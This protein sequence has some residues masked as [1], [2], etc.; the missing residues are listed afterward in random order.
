MAEVITDLMAGT[1]SDEDRE[2]FLRSVGLYESLSPLEA[3]AIR[4]EWP[5]RKIL[6]VIGAG[7]F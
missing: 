7:L 2:A 4:D 3:Q 6:R 1:V 5:D